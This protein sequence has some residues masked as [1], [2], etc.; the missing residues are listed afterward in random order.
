MPY[1]AK[2]LHYELREFTYKSRNYLLITK[3]KSDRN[4]FQEESDLY[5]IGGF[6]PIKSYYGGRA[7]DEQATLYLEPTYQFYQRLEGVEEENFLPEKILN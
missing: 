7:D 2:G 6:G 3:F 1:F 5:Q 4:S